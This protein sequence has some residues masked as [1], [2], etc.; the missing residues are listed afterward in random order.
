MRPTQKVS[1]CLLLLSLVSP[2]RRWDGVY[3]FIIDTK[4]ILQDRFKCSSCSTVRG[5]IK[6]F[7]QNI[8][9][10]DREKAE[11]HWWEHAICG[12]SA[13]ACGVCA[14]RLQH[15]A[16]YDPGSSPFVRLC[17]LVLRS[18]RCIHCGASIPVDRSRCARAMVNLNKCT[19][20]SSGMVY[21]H[22]RWSRFE[23]KILPVGAHSVLS[24]VSVSR[25]SIP[26]AP[27][28][29]DEEHTNQDWKSVAKEGRLWLSTGA[30][31]FE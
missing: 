16:R 21:N 17:R 5:A 22:H 19:S 11:A 27:M 1:H 18:L 13:H 6:A 29:S 2:S 23:W 10:Y 31:A 12:G 24:Q 20:C 3:T 15:S 7:L 4:D 8:D 25:R 14:I 30:A 28:H 9:H 26:Q